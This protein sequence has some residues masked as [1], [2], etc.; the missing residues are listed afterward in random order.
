MEFRQYY[1]G[2]YYPLTS[3]SQEADVWM[4]YQLDRPESGD[5]LLVVLR[6]PSSPYE[7]ARLPL[8]ALDRAATYEVTNLDGGPPAVLTGAELAGKG[9]PLTLKRKPDTVLMRYRRR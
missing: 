1:Y 4:A 7:F 6:R 3:Y 2:D 8:E 9:L 5:G